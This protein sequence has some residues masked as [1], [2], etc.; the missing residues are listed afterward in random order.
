MVA[1][2]SVTIVS[3]VSVCTTVVGTQVGQHFP[4]VDCSTRSLSEIRSDEFE[5]DTIYIELIS[6][7][8][9]K[10]TLKE[11]RRELRTNRNQTVE[12]IKIILA[13]FKC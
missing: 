11:L 3:V 7:N 13:M 4:W 10:D 12:G 6:D 8:N 2:Y 5:I 1:H 9:K